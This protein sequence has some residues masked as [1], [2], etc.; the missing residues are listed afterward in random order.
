MSPLLVLKSRGTL[1]L[2]LIRTRFRGRSGLRL[3]AQMPLHPEVN[4]QNDGDDGCGAK[5]QNRKQNLHH[6][7]ISGYQNGGKRNAFF[8]PTGVRGYQNEI[9]FQAGTRESPFR[10]LD[11]RSTVPI[12]PAKGQSRK[13]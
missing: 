5:H 8:H 12:T 2:P 10:V 6:H 7:G 1:V 13:S 4:S 9:C 3:L 11:F